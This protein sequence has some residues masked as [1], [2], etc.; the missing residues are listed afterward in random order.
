MLPELRLGLEIALEND[1]VNGDGTGEH[2][3]DLAHVSGHHLQTLTTDKLAN[4]PAG[5]HEAGGAEP[6]DTRPQHRPKPDAAPWAVRHPGLPGS[7]M[8]TPVPPGDWASMPQGSTTEAR[9]SV[10]RFVRRTRVGV[11][12]HQIEGAGRLSD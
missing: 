1:I 5:D 7:R 8:L 10:T 6:G 12:D 9:S 4:G 3:T 11:S 2:L